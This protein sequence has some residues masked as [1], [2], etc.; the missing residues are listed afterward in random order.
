MDLTCSAHIEGAV[1][2]VR[3]TGEISS[4]RSSEATAPPFSEAVL[5]GFCHSGNPA[6]LGSTGV[7]QNGTVPCLHYY[8]SCTS[9][10][11]EA[12][13]GPRALARPLSY[14]IDLHRHVLA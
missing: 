7:I 14:L 6:A 8:T 4:N 12:N 1:S 3:V 5:V 10:C 2:G 11:W 13:Q 9:G